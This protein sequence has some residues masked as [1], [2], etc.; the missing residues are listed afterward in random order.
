MG[1][2]MSVNG[3]SD[4]PPTRVGE[5]LGDLAAALYGAQAIL[6]ALRARKRDGHGQQRDI[7]ILDSFFS[8]LVSALSQYRFSGQVRGQI[9]NA[10]PISAPLDSF[11]ARRRRTDHRRC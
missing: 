10:N 8:P 4:G 7:A 9:G 3:S 11:R 5:S 2:I 6:A 1:G